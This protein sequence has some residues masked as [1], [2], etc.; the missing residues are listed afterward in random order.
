MGFAAGPLSQR[1]ALD[2]L[3]VC[4]LGPVVGEERPE[5]APEDA[6]AQGPPQGVEGGRHRPDALSGSS[7]ASCTR[8]GLA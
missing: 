1:G 4:E 8:Q 6:G 3:R 2:A 5:E 7:S